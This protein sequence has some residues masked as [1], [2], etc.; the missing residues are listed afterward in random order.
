MSTNCRLSSMQ[1]TVVVLC[2]SQESS[3]W[4]VKLGKMEEKLFDLWCPGEW[5]RKGEGSSALQVLSSACCFWKLSRSDPTGLV[6][7]TKT[8]LSYWNN[9]ASWRENARAVGQCKSKASWARWW[10]TVFLC[11]EPQSRYHS[12]STL[13]LPVGHLDWIGS[14]G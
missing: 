6:F 9:W 3:T 1:P 14:T 4:G 5:V 2:Q 12:S 8:S 11:Q 13:Y 7:S 10:C